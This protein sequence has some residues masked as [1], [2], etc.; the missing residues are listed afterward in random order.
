MKLVF[1]DKK[2][3]GFDTDTSGLDRFGTVE[4]YDWITDMD[5]SRYLADADVV[6][7]NQNKLNA[8]NLACADKLKL[9]CQTGTGYNNLDIEYCRKNGIAVTNVPGYAAVS[10]A[11]HTFAMLFYL[12]SHSS[13]YDAYMKEG[14]YSSGE[15]R[16]PSK[17]FFELEGKTWGIIGLGD[18][19]RKVAAYAQG[20]GCSV[21]YF[22]SSGEDRSNSLKRM[23]L[24][25]LLNEADIVSVH[26]PMNERT[27]GLI[28]LKEMKMMKQSAYLLN[29]GRG[30][31]IVEKD[32]A[33]ALSERIIAGA[34]L[35]VFE[36]EPLSPDNPLLTVVDSGTLYMSPHIGY[37]SREARARLMDTICSN[38]ESF[39]KGES[40]NRI[41]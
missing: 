40:R 5:A 6:I 30:G 33:Q 21:V 3:L 31:I 28:G 10:V 32:L 37:G 26:A 9:I 29:L 34:G 2:T 24:D 35:D 39:L 1:L 7:T 22:S 14:R 20:F 41:V 16:D 36:E 38:I 23:E 18:I 4:I 19:G 27:R 12:L 13:Y 11:Q 25:E 8:A 15:V 17:D